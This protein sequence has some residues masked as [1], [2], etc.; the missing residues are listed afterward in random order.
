MRYAEKLNI[1]EYA[2]FIRS[3]YN[4]RIEKIY[5][6]ALML[7]HIHMKPYTERNYVDSENINGYPKCIERI[8]ALSATPW[9]AQMLNL[10]WQWEHFWE[11]CPRREVGLTKKSS[12]ITSKSQKSCQCLVSGN[13]ALFCFPPLVIIYNLWTRMHTFCNWVELL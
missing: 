13:E 3:E 8:S 12:S 11:E 5:A 7:A 2:V 1:C 9:P 10:E 4:R 6:H